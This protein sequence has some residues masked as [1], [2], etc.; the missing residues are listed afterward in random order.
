MQSGQ[1]GAQVGEEGIGFQCSEGGVEGLDD[2]GIHAKGEQ[3]LGAPI[4]I[5]DEPDWTFGS[6]KP[7][8]MRVKSQHC[9]QASAASCR[10]HRR[11]N[12]RAVAK[13]NPVEHTD[14]EM[15]G[16]LGGQTSSGVETGVN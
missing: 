9:R 11:L 15:E 13:V 12:H 7:A 8:G 16:P 1:A 4:A 3:G 2:H 5:H 10:P 14:G 6:K